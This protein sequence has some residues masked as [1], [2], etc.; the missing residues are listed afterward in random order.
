MLNEGK[1]ACLE[2]VKILNL[3]LSINIIQNILVID[4]NKEVLLNFV[5]VESFFLVEE[6]NFY[7]IE[8]FLSNSLKKIAI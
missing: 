6:I 2:L 3:D 7:R 5:P 8:F 1:I 4:V